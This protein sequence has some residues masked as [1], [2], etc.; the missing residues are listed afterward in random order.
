VRDIIIVSGPSGCGK[1]TLIARLR[2]EFPELG[3]SVS[4]TTRPPRPGEQD[5]REYHFLSAARFA[6]MVRAGGFAEWAVV[7]GQRY[8]TSWKEVRDRTR[9]G[10]TVLLDVDVQGARAIRRRFPEAIA[11]FIVPPSLAALKQRLR[12]RQQRL[13][14]EARRRLKAALGEL[15]AW[16]GYDYIVVNDELE[17][18]LADL[19]CLLRAFRLRAGR[20]GARMA[21]LLRRTT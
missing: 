6:A 10:G 18:A 20:G 5:G 12:R 3:F 8:G 1:S 15:R 19:R 11:V 14:D 16:R 7:H 13:D 17:A 2:R 4:H 21:R 9:N